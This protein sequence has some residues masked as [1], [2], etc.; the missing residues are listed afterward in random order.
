MAALSWNST[1]RTVWS[2][3][4]LRDQNY[5]ED[6]AE[7]FILVRAVA[8]QGT[9]PEDHDLL[10]F[11]ARF[12]TTAYP[13]NYLWGPGSRGEALAW[14][15][16][17]QPQGD[18]VDYIDRVLLV[19]EHEGTVFLPMRAEVAA[20][21]PEVHRVGRWH[22]VRADFATD[23]LGHVRGGHRTPSGGDCRTRGC[24]VHILGSD[25]HPGPSQLLPRCSAASLLPCRHQSVC[26]RTLNR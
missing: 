16:E 15:E 26:P 20:G 1:G 13:A 21:I 23:A 11:D 18:T 5:Q 10:D 14:V 12:E 6:Q 4:A 22:A 7:T 2:I 8:Q 17:H 25:D 3:D 9:Y 19:R 24:P